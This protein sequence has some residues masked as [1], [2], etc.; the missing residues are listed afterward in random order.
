M[1]YETFADFNGTGLTS[2]FIYPPRIV[3]IFTPLLLFALLSIVTLSTF[4]AQKKFGNE[5]DF[6]VSFVVA[7][8]FTAVIA[9]V[10]TLIEG[11]ID[12]VTL[13]ITIIIAIIGVILLMTRR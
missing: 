9:I 10:M 4:F 2:F 3:P 12:G 13:S 5:G 1:A 7:S 11:M 6:L 8:F